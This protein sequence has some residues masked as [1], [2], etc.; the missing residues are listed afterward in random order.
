MSQEE[1]WSPKA[2]TGYHE[3]T[4]LKASWREKNSCTSVLCISVHSRDNPTL[5]R[6]GWPAGSNVWD[7]SHGFH[8][9]IG[10]ERDTLAKDAYGHL[11][12]LL[13]KQS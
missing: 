4:P 11:P 6:V 2:P 1:G 9:M 3:E 12:L 7:P 10:M 8:Q 13:Q 5:W